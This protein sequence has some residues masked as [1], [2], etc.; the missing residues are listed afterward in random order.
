LKAKAR[1]NVVFFL[2]RE[3][4]GSV[5]HSFEDEQNKMKCSDIQPNLSFYAEGSLTQDESTAV[6][7]H[8]TVCP[9]CRQT[10]S[11]LRSVRTGLNR[12]S[13]PEMPAAVRN[14]LTS[15]VNHQRRK[16][17]YAWPPFSGE[18]LIA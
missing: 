13:R 3:Q 9:V 15:R 2:L 18:L 12:M 6:R 7:E 8:L 5:S 4:P 11:E 1:Q 17:E 16:E 14:S 10:E